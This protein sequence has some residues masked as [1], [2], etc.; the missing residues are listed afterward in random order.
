MIEQE[1][2]QCVQAVVITSLLQGK[3][4][5]DA[6]CGSRMFWF[7][8]SNKNVL[9]ADIRQEEH[10]LCDGRPLKIQPDIV[11][12]FRNMPFPDNSFQMFV[13]DPPHLHKLGQDTWMA[14]KYG[15]LFPTWENDIAAGFQECWRVLKPGGT[16]IFKWN[17][18]QIKLNQVLPLFTQKPLFRHV[19]GKHGRTIWVCFMK[20]G[21]K[22]LMQQG[23]LIY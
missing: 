19:T 17:E 10:T 14:K 18:I 8:K 9:F 1:N 11:L 7:D 2:P 20:G 22:T 6:C 21:F 16:L 23:Q 12:D 15:V 13:F 5:L 4:I 3:S